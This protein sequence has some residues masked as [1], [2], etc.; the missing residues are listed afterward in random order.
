L[1]KDT[2]IKNKYPTKPLIVLDNSKVFKDKVK[3]QRRISYDPG[4]NEII[5]LDGRIDTNFH[6]HVRQLNELSNEMK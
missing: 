3:H 6:G 4:T 2:K 5:I 1:S